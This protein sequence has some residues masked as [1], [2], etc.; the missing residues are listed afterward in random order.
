MKINCF[1][2]NKVKIT[3][4]FFYQAPWK[5]G[6]CAQVSKL[7]VL[8]LVYFK[9]MDFIQL[10]SAELTEITLPGIVT[11]THAQE[12]LCYEYSSA[13]VKIWG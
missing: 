8:T 7:D 12:G 6:Q 11:S 10:E 4:E 9:Y 13:R 5:P 3:Q 1:S 2:V